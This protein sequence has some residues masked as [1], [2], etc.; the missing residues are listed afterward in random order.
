MIAAPF[1]KT[2]LSRAQSRIWSM[3]NPVGDPYGGPAYGEKREPVSMIA[4]VVAIGYGATAV[5]AATTLTLTAVMGGLMVAGGA[6]ALVGTVSGNKNLAMIGGIVAGVGGLGSAAANMFASAAATE[7]GVVAGSEAGSSGLI[8]A[9]PDPQVGMEAANVSAP[10]SGLTDAIPDPQ[11]AANGAFNQPVTGDLATQNLASKTDGGLINDA[12]ATNNLDTSVAGQVADLTP[13]VQ[14]PVDDITNQLASN[15]SDA[16]ANPLQPSPYEAVADNS[17]NTPLV[18]KATPGEDLTKYL[19]DSNY[20]EAL[21]GTSNTPVAEDPFQNGVGSLKGITEEQRAALAKQGLENAKNNW[22]TA[23]GS[24]SD[25]GILDKVEGVLGGIE[26]YK[27]TAM[28]G[29]NLI[30]GAMKYAI[31]SQ[32][33]EAL[34]NAYNARANLA[35][36]EASNLAAAEERKRQY[37]EAL[38]KLKIPTLYQAAAPNQFSAGTSGAGIINTARA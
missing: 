29:G 22:P 28:L 14:N 35:N 25:S 18:P 16:Q 12:L 7:A 23:P 34:M 33:D 36:Q 15:L 4:A 24:E 8:D 21:N 20:Q 19:K 31:P 3:D 9:I 10:A 32:Q 30:S 2:Y 1:E 6:M 27:T 26:K 13:T 5:A 17:G 11:V 38:K 37:Q